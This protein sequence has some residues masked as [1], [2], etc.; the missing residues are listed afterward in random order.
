M[1]QQSREAKVRGQRIFPF[2]GSSQ[3]AQPLRAWPPRAKARGRGWAAG[4]TSEGQKCLWQ[5]WDARGGPFCRGHA[6]GPNPLLPAQQHPVLCP[7]P[8]VLRGGHSSA[9]PLLLHLSSFLLLLQHSCS[10][11]QIPPAGHAADSKSAAPRGPS[12]E[13][14]QEM[15]RGKVWLSPAG[16]SG[17]HHAASL[18]FHQ[19]LQSLWEGSTKKPP[20]AR[21]KHSS[22]CS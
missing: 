7:A 5:V 18:L 10:C 21:R 6:E 14:R 12:T 20:P 22:G 11:T 13:Q 3:S 1:Q 2:S 16:S 17:F 8:W 4:T 15:G 9:L 19:A